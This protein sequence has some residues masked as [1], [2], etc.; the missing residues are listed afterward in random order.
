MQAIARPLAR[1]APKHVRYAGTVSAWS[2][3]P[4]GT[5]DPILGACVSGFVFLA[6]VSMR[7]RPMPPRDSFN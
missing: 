4:A 2:A 5:P 1:A 7:P 3:V 6:R